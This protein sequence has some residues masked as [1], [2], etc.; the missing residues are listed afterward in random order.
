MLKEMD[1]TKLEVSE[2][3]FIFIL[4]KLTLITNKK[5]KLSDIKGV[6]STLVTSIQKLFF[7]ISKKETDVE[8]SMAELDVA[9]DEFKRN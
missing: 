5:P 6:K 8:V 7:N 3:V 1:Y 4:H 9:H 2:R